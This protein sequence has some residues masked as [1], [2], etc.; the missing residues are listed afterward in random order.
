MR[1]VASREEIRRE[2]KNV[3]E[4]VARSGKMIRRML[5]EEL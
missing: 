2:E 4:R 1:R 3:R 5:V